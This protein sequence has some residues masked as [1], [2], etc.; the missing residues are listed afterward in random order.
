MKQPFTIPQ[1]NMD[2][3]IGGGGMGDR[4]RHGPHLPNTIRCIVCGPSNCGKTNAVFNLLFA[5]NGLVFKNIYIF[6]K[7][8]YQ[9]K[10]KFL[11]EVMKGIPEIGYFTFSENEHVISPEEA[12]PHSI[13]IF[14]DVACE[15]QQNIRKYFSM[16]RHNNVDSFYLTQTYSSVG[17]HLVRDNANLIVLFKQDDLNLRHVYHDHVNTDMKFEKFKELCSRAWKEP[18]SFLV[19]DKESDINSG[20]YRIGFDTFIKNID[21]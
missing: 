13:M 14:D 15:K 2:K 8:L 6:S 16:G 18:H 11:A 12:R 3:Y 1:V 10:Y 5:R 20:R 21:T 9:P 7:S 17:K 4:L 19:V